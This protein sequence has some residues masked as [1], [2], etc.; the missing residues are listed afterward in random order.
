MEEI[1]N[2]KTSSILLP[3]RP[4]LQRFGWVILAAWMLIVFLL[5]NF[6]LPGIFSSN[7]DLYVLQPALW[8]SLAA[9]TIGLRLAEGERVRGIGQREIVFSG[10]MLGGIQAAAGVL[11][12]LLLGFGSSPYARQAIWVLLN[13]W[14][15]ASRLAGIEM[16]R[17]YLAVSAGRKNPALGFALAWLLPLLLW[18][19]AGA[20]SLLGQPE[21]AFRLTGQT[22]L[23]AAAESML[24]AFLSSTGGP[25]A[26]I[27]YRGFM[28]AFEWLSPI[29][30]DLP[31]MA[32]AFVGVLVPV[33]GLF[34]LNR[35]AVVPAQP[36]E[37]KKP[38]K[39]RASA[40]SWLLVGALA[41]GVIWFNSGA[42]GVQPSL[43]SGNSMNPLLYPGDIV[44]VQKTAPE[45]IQVG[46]VIRFHRDGIDV[47]HRVIAIS[48]ESGQRVFTTRGDNNNVADAPVAASQFEGKVILRVPKIGWI[49][50]YLR[51]GLSW[52]TGQL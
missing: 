52:I 26:S 51:Q 21:S 22:L 16:A 12:G 14:F 9:L 24:A 46:E 4:V 45:K 33:L 10:L 2:L 18:I 8:L 17:W 3:I 39:E 34:A 5:L 28:Q 7:L 50:I 29:L 32:A 43:V 44:V 42:F 38:D 41:V 49:S 15:V 19:P 27:A 23:P 37:T 11:L 6:V 48:Q 40:A 20:Y 47:V 13:L 36:V 1:R 35:Q 31:W 30:P 25:L